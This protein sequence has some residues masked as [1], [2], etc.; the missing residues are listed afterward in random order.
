MYVHTMTMIQVTNYKHIC[1]YAPQRLFA[2]NTMSLKLSLEMHIITR[3]MPI[4]SVVGNYIR[5][6]V[7]AINWNLKEAEL[8]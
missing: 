5:T 4:D 6:Y 3:A 1:V 8:V 2:A 7:S